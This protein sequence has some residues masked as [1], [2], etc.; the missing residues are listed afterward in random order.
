MVKLIRT[1]GKPMNDTLT[2]SLKFWRTILM[3][4]GFVVPASTSSAAMVSSSSRGGE[5]A[6]S[7]ICRLNRLC[8]FGC[9]VELSV[10]AMT[11]TSNVPAMASLATSSS[12]LASVA[13]AGI[14]TGLS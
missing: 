6:G 9:E 3:A 8:V 2:G 10:T 13:S 1:V 4:T 5:G 14:V 12:G 7:T 11:S